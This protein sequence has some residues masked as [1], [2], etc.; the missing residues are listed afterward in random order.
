MI[1]AMVETTERREWEERQ[2]VLIAELQHR[3]RNLMGV[4]RSMADKTAQAS[5]DFD[6][7]R[8]RFGDRLEALARVQ[9]LLSRLNEHDRVTFDELIETEL[10]AMGAAGERIRLEGPRGI[11][12]RSST[13]QT[14][15]LALHELATNAVKYGALGQADGRL[16]VTWHLVEDAASGR[17]WLHIEWR[18]AGVEMPSP[19]VNPRGGGQG[20]ELIER[21]LPYQLGA[22]TSYVLGAN[23]VHCTIVI[24][25]FSRPPKGS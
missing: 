15:A 23:G 16:A 19:A 14:L 1:G 11:R 13:V 3:T 25:V 9:G 22:R 21:A 7:F 2:Q 24:P 10:A 6:E 20:R 5:S 17:P 18:E 12:L 4:V 8:S